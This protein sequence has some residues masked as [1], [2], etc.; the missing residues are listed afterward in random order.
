MMEKMSRSVVAKK[1]ELE[2][3]VVETQAAQIQLDKAAEDFR[4][5]RGGSRGGRVL[6]RL[7]GGHP[8]VHSMRGHACL[9]VCVRARTHTAA[10]LL[11]KRRRTLELLLPS[12]PSKLL[13]ASIHGCKQ[14]HPRASAHH[15][16]PAFEPA[17]QEAAQ[18]APGADPAVGGRHASHEPPRQGHRAR[19]RA[20]RGGWTAACAVPASRGC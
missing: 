4:C 10:S 13:P 7:G 11:L 15:P 19:I 14:Q 8:L 20:G 2:D 16:L 1:A 18:R 3:E 6:C 5:G 9:C 12:L 17:T